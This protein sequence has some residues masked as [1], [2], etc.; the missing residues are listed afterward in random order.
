MKKTRII[1]LSLSLILAIGLAGLVGCNNSN[2]GTAGGTQ[3]QGE[4]AGTAGT[5]GTAAPVQSE[6]PKEDD[7]ADNEVQTAVS[8]YPIAEPGTVT[9][10]Y[11]VTL[12]NSASKF[13]ESYSDNTA[14]QQAEKDTGVKI[15]YIH[16]AISQEQE[17]FNLMIVS[18]DYPDIMGN[19][20]FYKGGEFQGMYDGVFADLS[21]Y[22][23]TYAPDY[24]KLIEEDEEFYRE[25]SD[26][27]GAMSAMYAY[28]PFGDPPFHRALLRTD[29]LDELGKDI[30]K[31][32]ADYEDL[33][34]AML[35]AGITPFLM[36][37]NGYTIQFIGM[38]GTKNGFAKDSS[39]QIYYGQV[40]PEFKEYLTKMNEWYDK[41][42]ISKDFTTL[43]SNQR[44][45]LFDTKKVGFMFD[46]IVANFNRGQTQGFEVTAAPYPRLNEGDQLHY[47]ET[48][49]WPKQ[50]NGAMQASVSSKS[51]NIVEAVRW[52]NYGYTEE[53]ADLYNWGVEGLNYDVVNGEKVYNDLMLN[54]E[55]FGTE[56]A[57]YIYKFHF[58]P[59]LTEFDVVCH[60]NLLKSP[61]SLASRMKWAD[62]PGIDSEACLPPYQL[63]TEEQ[64]LR[65][66][67]MTQ[68][69][70]YTDEMVLKFI[71]GAESL[72]N[73]D[74]FVA[75]IEGMGLEEVL[76]S[77]QKA[78]ER[79]MNKKLNK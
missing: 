16:P 48:N 57:S 71:T 54:N 65:T 23:P 42:Y 14:A 44:N 27:N 30:P 45:T 76:V 79:Y 39:G 69:N 19:S 74:S 73:F 64:E 56:E 70:T 24:W 40:R 6:A 55:K 41:G 4:T 72:D 50:G 2:T 63:T 8:E 53:G 47:E 32:L 15:E 29:V 49:I 61:A 3:T 77:E 20:Q 22:L 11:W 67:V 59:K 36:D 35:E 78:Y 18:G 21:E 43:D 1:A 28:K 38:Y 58:I 33:F 75:T 31:T 37:K 34:D 5:A 17:Q 26:E 60:A 46:A 66:R 9:L 25:V 10:R 51:K 13:I 7:N 68:V 62:D 52:L 12:N